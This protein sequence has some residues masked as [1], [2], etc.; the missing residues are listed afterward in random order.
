MFLTQETVSSAFPPI[1][2][3]KIRIFN[4]LWPHH[5]APGVVEKRKVLGYRVVSRG[6]F[7]GYPLNRMNARVS[8]PVKS[9][10]SVNPMAS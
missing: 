9:R 4:G 10:D 1:S 7:T 8:K 6:L 2:P 5:V 3:Y